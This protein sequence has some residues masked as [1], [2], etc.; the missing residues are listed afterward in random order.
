MRTFTPG[1]QAL[2]RLIIVPC[3]RHDGMDGDRIAVDADCE[4]FTAGV[5]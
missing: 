1:V 2:V 3:S 5:E 4:R